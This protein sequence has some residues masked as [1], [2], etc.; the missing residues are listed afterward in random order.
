ML[1]LPWSPVTDER[2]LGAPSSTVRTRTLGDGVP[3]LLR[4][5][6]GVVLRIAP[7]PP[8]P[9]VDDAWPPFLEGPGSPGGRNDGRREPECSP[10]RSTSNVLRFEILLP[11]LPTTA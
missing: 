5:P 8:L 3:A 6:P 7:A 9:P 1:F 2:P 10:V 4:V 11:P